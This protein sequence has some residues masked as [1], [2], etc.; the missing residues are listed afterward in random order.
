MTTTTTT[1]TIRSNSQFTCNQ[2]GRS[3]TYH[4]HCFSPGW[5][6]FS[7]DPNK[8]K[9]NERLLSCLCGMFVGVRLLPPASVQTGDHLPLSGAHRVIFYFSTR[10]SH[11]GCTGAPLAVL[12]GI[13]TGLRPV[14]ALSGPVWTSFCCSGRLHRG[15]TGL[16][17]KGIIVTRQTVAGDF[18]MKGSSMTDWHSVF[19]YCLDPTDLLT[20]GTQFIRVFFTSESK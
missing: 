15:W 13:R 16:D 9:N 19:E 2:I 11:R 1:T 20:V 17:R 7:V 3:F 8:I 5:M 12:S 6:R 10:E 14:Q 18:P 4:F